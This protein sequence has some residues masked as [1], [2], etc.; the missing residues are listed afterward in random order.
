MYVV[1][2]AGVGT[3]LAARY[4]DSAVCIRTGH[5]RGKIQMETISKL[6][7]VSP[8][9]QGPT[10]RILLGPVQLSKRLAFTYDLL[11]RAGLHALED[12]G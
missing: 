2:V 6:S 1:A 10:A 8:E 7:G 11:V 9:A 12:S 4:G 3:E 5:V